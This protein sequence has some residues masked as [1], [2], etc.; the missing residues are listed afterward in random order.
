VKVLGRPTFSTNFA[1]GNL[2][3]SL[4]KLQLTAPTFLI[5]T[6]PLHLS[7]NL[8]QLGTRVTCWP[9]GVAR[10]GKMGVIRAKMGGEGQKGKH[11][12][13]HDFWW[14]QNCILPGR[15]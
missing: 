3:L 11:Q 14:R 12:P 9:S 1:V 15:R 5:H 2:Q 8:R 6:A 7:Q 4:R 10:G 13:S